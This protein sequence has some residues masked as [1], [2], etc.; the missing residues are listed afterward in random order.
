LEIL[1]EFLV[2]S[3]SQKFSPYNGKIIQL[4]VL[5]HCSEFRFEELTGAAIGGVEFYN[6]QLVGVGFEEGTLEKASD[7]KEGG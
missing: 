2:A 3:T 1:K 7:K 6:D 5:F 4:F